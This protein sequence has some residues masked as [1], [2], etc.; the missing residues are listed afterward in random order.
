[1][2]LDREIVCAG[3]LIE[4]KAIDP[5]QTILVGPC[6]NYEGGFGPADGRV[7]VQGEANDRL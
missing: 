1:M 7:V 5:A 4:Q 2:H 3:R 6:E